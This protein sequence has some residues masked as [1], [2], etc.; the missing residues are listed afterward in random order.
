MTGIYL[1]LLAVGI[2]KDLLVGRLLGQTAV[3]FFLVLGIGSLIRTRFEF[4]PRW[5]IMALILCALFY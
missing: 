1:L 3:L 4:S 5:L 2:L